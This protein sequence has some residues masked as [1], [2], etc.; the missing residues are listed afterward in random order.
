[1]ASSPAISPQIAVDAP[2]ALVSKLQ[3]AA[4]TFPRILKKHKLTFWSIILYQNNA[5][6]VENEVENK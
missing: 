1:M 6:I 2:N 5:F 3:A 4:K